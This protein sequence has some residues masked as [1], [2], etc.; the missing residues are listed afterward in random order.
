MN[1]PSVPKQ[2]P[3][4]GIEVTERV[5]KQLACPNVECDKLLDITHINA[6]TKIQCENCGNVTWLPEYKKEKWWQKTIFTIGF[7]LMSFIF[8]VLSSLLASYIYSLLPG[9]GK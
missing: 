9:G 8:G 5:I 3:S 4:P 6:G 2:L 1:I 7:Y